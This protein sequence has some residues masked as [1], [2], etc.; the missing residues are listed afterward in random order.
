MSILKAP[1]NDLTPLERHALNCMSS[2]F[3]IVVIFL[4]VLTMAYVVYM[5]YSLVVLMFHGFNV[6]EA[7]HQ[8]LLAIILLELFELIALY[9]K[10]HHVSMRRVAELGVVAL[11]RKLV[12]TTDY[13]A[14]GWQTLFGTAAIMFALGWIYVEERRRVSEEERFVVEH[15][16]LEGK[17]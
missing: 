11:V 1:K 8:F 6:E 13:S 10:E 5:L 2:M 15:G 7:L 9:I 14:L 16:M 12:I 3:D 4:G 17:D